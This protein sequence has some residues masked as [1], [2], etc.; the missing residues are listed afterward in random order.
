VGLLSNTSIGLAPAMINKLAHARAGGRDEEDS[1]D[2][3]ADVDAQAVAL[4]P[5]SPPIAATRRLRNLEQTP[6]G[7]AVIARLY[8]SG[9]ALALLLAV[10]GL[11]LCAG[12]GAG[13]THIHRIPQ[14]YTAR[15]MFWFVLFMGA[16]IVARMIA[17]VP[18]A[19]LQMH[20]RIALD[21]VLLALCEIVWI[22]L[23]AGAMLRRMPLASVGLSFAIANA[24]LLAAR[25][26]CARPH[27]G[28]MRLAEARRPIMAALLMFGSFVMLAD[29]AEFLYAPTDYILIN[30]L[31][32]PVEVATY[33][34]AVQI[35][36]ALLLMVMAVA[37]V[38]LPRAAL[39]HH[40]GDRSRV[41]R[42]YWVGTIGTALLLVA[43]AIGARATCP[44][45]FRIWFNA[46][47]Y[48]TRA[49][50]SWV[51]IHTVIGGSSAVG[52]SI[53]I[54]MGKVRAFT[55]AVLIAAVVNVILSF[56]FVEYCGL[57]LKGIVLGTI[58]AVVGR[59]GVWMPWYV[60]KTLREAERPATGCSPA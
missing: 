29:L 47:M 24:G 54:G 37:D 33:A 21:N 60:I 50:L 52:R 26:V 53:L 14:G 55:A 58:V 25:L 39:A 56:V 41:R 19:V 10:A 7:A 44:I 45:I 42:Y 18:A 57:G 8:S 15:G 40:A 1:R 46:K 9:M 51:L 27:G 3:A 28:P 31:L 5:S 34:P 48:A 35:D 20:D 32:S 49:I 4:A 30:R 17:D 38:L 16:G 11:A 2:S 23:S 13:F 6:A 36:G 22:I 59:C 12:Y 43:A